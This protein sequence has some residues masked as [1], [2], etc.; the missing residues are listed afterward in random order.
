MGGTYQAEIFVIT[1]AVESSRLEPQ[2]VCAHYPV[3]NDPTAAI[4]NKPYFDHW[5]PPSV[6][7]NPPA[8]SRL[9]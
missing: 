6:R 9:R 3:G 7:L 5:L 4:A 2:L 8:P 1:R